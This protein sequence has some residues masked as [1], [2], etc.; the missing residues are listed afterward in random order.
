MGLS[1]LKAMI[2]FLHSSPVVVVPDFHAGKPSTTSPSMLPDA[3]TAGEH[4]AG[5]EADAVSGIT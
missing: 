1:D 3:W 5:G 2:K 4:T